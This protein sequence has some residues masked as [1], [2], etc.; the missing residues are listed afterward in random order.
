MNQT[1]IKL[2]NDLV[3]KL[4]TDKLVDADLNNYDNFSLIRDTI[5]DNSQPNQKQSLATTTEESIFDLKPD[6]SDNR[7]L[8][9]QQLGS[10]TDIIMNNSPFDQSFGWVGTSF[11]ANSIASTRC[12]CAYC[13]G[14]ST[15][16]I[17]AANRANNS[18]RDTSP[19]AAVAPNAANF[20]IDKKT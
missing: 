3:G 13:C 18:A 2:S 5:K 7:S 11:K 6:Q 15:S 10:I 20:S 4:E 1:I 19:L 17:G 8:K 14:L 9:S 12:S 16:N